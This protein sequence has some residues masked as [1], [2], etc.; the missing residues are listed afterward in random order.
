[1]AA[2]LNARAFP[3]K[4]CNEYL[5][6]LLD[7]DA[8][9]QGSARLETQLILAAAHDTDY[10]KRDEVPRIQVDAGPAIRVSANV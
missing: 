6:D 8:A 10:S 1:M 3:A 4:P 2:A 7:R 9:M 5:A